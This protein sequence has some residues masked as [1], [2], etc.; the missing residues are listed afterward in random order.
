MI[1]G[2]DRFVVISGCSGGGKSTLLTELNR[3][4]FAVVAEP[5]R[6]I[7]D[8]E[9]ASGGTALPWIDMEGFLRR[10]I[11]MAKADR[12]AARGNQGITFFDRGLVDAASALETLTG[13][14]AVARDCHDHRYASRVYL[15]PPWPEIY[16]TDSARQHD[17]AAA[18]IEYDRLATLYPALGYETLVL[19]KVAIAERADIVLASLTPFSVS[20]ATGY[21]ENEFGGG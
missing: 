17:L 19:P 7:V 3:R 9:K 13:E 6:R 5:G 11:T 12:E 14:P 1:E 4:G 15:T 21:P 10:A 2:V 16:V 8:A 18:I 20:G